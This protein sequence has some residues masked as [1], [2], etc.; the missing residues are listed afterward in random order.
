MTMPIRIHP[1]RGVQQSSFAGVCFDSSGMWARALT[2]A[3]RWDC[4]LAA[5]ALIELTATEIPW[6]GR[7]VDARL[8]AAYVSFREHCQRNGVRS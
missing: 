7:D 4:R 2:R 8:R 6:P 1:Q 5:E 3:G